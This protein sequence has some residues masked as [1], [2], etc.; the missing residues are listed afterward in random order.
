MPPVDHRAW[1][2]ERTRALLADGPARRVIG[3]MVA[4]VDGR[5]A[6][7]GKSGGLS[8]EADRALLQAW[9]ARAGAVLVGARTLETERYGSLIP[10]ADRDARLARGET[11]CP[12]V[13]TVSRDLDL[14][15][16]AILSTDADLPLTVYTAADAGREI[17]GSDT[18]VLTLP[19]VSLAA[20]LADARRRYGCDVVACEGGPR[21]LAA[22]LEEGVITDL[23][24]TLA[25][26][27]LG[28]GPPLLSRADGADPITL[29]AV[30]AEVID[31][32]AFV[33]YRLP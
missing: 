3:V 15:L 21:L 4:S 5:A 14:D 29:T 19:E 2:L 24:L 12:R 17:P 32:S 10:D 13:L 25:P 7:D 31:G 33:H 6:V 1:A 27:V 20:V 16:D 9:R 8:S 26:M 11:G 22:A 30:A 28:D 23:S 18:Q